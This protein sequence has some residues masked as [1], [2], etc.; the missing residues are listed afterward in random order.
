MALRLTSRSGGETAGAQPRRSAVSG[1]RLRIAMIVLTVA[2]L[3]L[4]ALAVSILIG[5]AIA[6][7]DNFVTVSREL[8]FAILPLIGTWVGTV[9]AYYFSKDNFESAS[10]NVLSTFREAR[11]ERLRTAYVQDEMIQIASAVT[12]KWDESEDQNKK[13]GSDVIDVLKNRSVSRLVF[14]NANATARGVLHESLIFRFVSDVVLD[15]GKQ[16]NDFTVEQLLDHQYRSN[17][18]IKSVMRSSTAFVA[19]D[20]TLAMAKEAMERQTR[21]G[22]VV[23]RDVLVTERGQSDQMVVGWLTDSM[24]EN[25]TRAG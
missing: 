14:L 18:T 15:Q 25:F 19:S 10:Q 9:L 7:V 21:P 11:D 6:G 5:A 16:L 22:T 17:V 3:G 8:L 20:A 4:F 1:D 2:S 12:L 23:C 13:L 24:I